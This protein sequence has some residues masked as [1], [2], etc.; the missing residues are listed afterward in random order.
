[1]GV[2][3]A[4]LLRHLWR[5]KRPVLVVDGDRQRLFVPPAN[6]L[7]ISRGVKVKGLVDI[8]ARGYRQ[9]TM[10]VVHDEDGKEMVIPVFNRNNFDDDPTKFRD[11]ITSAEFAELCNEIA[12]L[13]GTS[14][15]IVER[16]QEIREGEGV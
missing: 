6:E 10:M 5:F 1:M 13:M 12:D 8:E 2:C 16:R 3:L 4:L 7:T 11:G 15:E 14:A 9:F